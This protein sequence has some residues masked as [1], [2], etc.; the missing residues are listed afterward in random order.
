ML[1]S[2]RLSLTEY[3]DFCANKDLSPALQPALTDYY[4]NQLG[5]KPAIIGRCDSDGRLVAAYPTLYGQVFPNVIHKRLLGKGAAKLG[6]FGQ[7]ETLIP[8]E[9]TPAKI[10]LNRLSPMTSALLK[11]RVREWPRRSLRSMA[12]SR[13]KSGRNPRQAAGQFLRGGGVAHFTSELD[14]DDFA[15]ILVRLYSQRWNR[16]PD[17]LRYVA[18]QV[19][20]VYEHV[21][22]CVLVDQGEPAAVLM[23][24]IAHGRT[25]DCIDAI[26]TATKP[27]ERKRMSYGSILYFMAA[28]RAEEMA[29]AARRELRYSYGFISGPSDYKNLWANAEPTFIAY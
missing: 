24:H 28:T 14:R 25:L 22:G 29:A 5:R 2:R 9:S 27:A 7:P 19:R 10:S 18:D 17:E 21:F 16:H 23:C 12:I 4:F 8:L 6:D 15:D 26:L 11:G 20:S 3:S 13:Q 1:R